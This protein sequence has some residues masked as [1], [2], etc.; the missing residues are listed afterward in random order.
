MIFFIYLAFVAMKS[1]QPWSPALTRSTLIFQPSTRSLKSFKLNSLNGNNN[2]LDE[3][4]K[5]VT[6]LL[7]CNLR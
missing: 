3:D 2:R 4:R 6:L 7:I 5:V 1:P